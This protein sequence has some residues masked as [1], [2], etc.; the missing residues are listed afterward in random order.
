MLKRGGTSTDTRENASGLRLDS[1]FA[2]LLP[3][4]RIDWTPGPR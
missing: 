4:G 3:T 1:S 2:S